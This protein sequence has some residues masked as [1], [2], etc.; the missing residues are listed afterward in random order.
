MTDANLLTVEKKAKKITPPL[1]D[2]ALERYLEANDEQAIL[3]AIT[4][5]C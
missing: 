2:V 4:G 1:L 3:K 5:V